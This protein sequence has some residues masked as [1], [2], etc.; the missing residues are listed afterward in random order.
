MKHLATLTALGMATLSMTACIFTD[1]AD[2]KPTTTP[3][4]KAPQTISPVTPPPSPQLTTT[5]LNSN[6]T[7]FDV[8]EAQKDIRLSNELKLT[9]V[10]VSV[11]DKDHPITLDLMTL[12]KGTSNL[13][14]RTTA[15]TTIGNEPYTHHTSEKAKAYKQDNSVVFGTT[16]NR[17]TI[18]RDADSLAHAQNGSG[19]MSPIIPAGSGVGLGVFSYEYLDKFHLTGNATD[20]LPTDTI[21]HYSGKS[22]NAKTEGTFDYTINFGKKEGFGQVT[23]NKETIPLEKGNITK[24]N[25]QSG[26]T[27]YGIQ[28]MKTVHAFDGTYT[29]PSY[30]LGIFGENAE[31]VAGHMKSNAKGEV[32]GIGFAGTKQ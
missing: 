10:K 13:D 23:L 24:L 19:S 9:Q 28:P 21:V 30:T 6:Y 18:R 25:N 8:E 29:T 16:Q 12:P 2:P 4:V 14:V 31:E 7:L 32:V 20:T 11:N 1:K 26:F 17:P 27:G 5:K 3:T 22:F 15:K